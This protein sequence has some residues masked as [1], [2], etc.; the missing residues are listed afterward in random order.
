M[1][2][3]SVQLAIDLA[4]QK[5]KSQLLERA[6]KIYPK[7]KYKIQKIAD[8]FHKGHFSIKILFLPNAHPELNPIEMLWGCIKRAVAAQNLSFKLRDVEHATKSELAKINAEQFEKFM[9]HT[10]KEESKYRALSTAI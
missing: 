7:P 10:L 5:S 2:W 6:K 1:E 8:K 9:N 3:S 4:H